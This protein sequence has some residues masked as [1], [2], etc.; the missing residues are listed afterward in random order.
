[1]PTSSSSTVSPIRKL[2]ARGGSPSRRGCTKAGR[3]NH[4]DSSEDE[5]ILKA[6]GKRSRAAPQ[7]TRADQPPA[8]AHKPHSR[9]LACRRPLQPGRRTRATAQPSAVATEPAPRK[10]PG[11]TPVD[12]P[13]AS[14]PAAGRHRQGTASERQSFSGHP[15]KPETCPRKH[16]G[17]G[18]VFCCH[19]DTP[20]LALGR[21]HA[22]HSAT[23]CGLARPHSH[24][25]TATA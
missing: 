6:R 8:H 17:Y 25:M 3:S 5:T 7:P 13:A 20:R 11:R 2:R 21:L 18:G 10:S 23:V 24:A 19:L 22:R 16:A 4:N 12:D 15:V 9:T 14:T 1:M